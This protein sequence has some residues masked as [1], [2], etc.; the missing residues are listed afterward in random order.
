M[1][2]RSAFLELY[3]RAADCVAHALVPEVARS[4]LMFVVCPVTAL[5]PGPDIF[6][7]AC[8]AA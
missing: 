3:E 4:V 6:C 2:S 1:W 7:R 5:V 8:T